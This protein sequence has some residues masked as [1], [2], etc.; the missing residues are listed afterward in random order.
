MAEQWRCAGELAQLSEDNP[1]EYKLDGVEVGIFKVGG[2]I[3]ALENV[4]PHAYAL[5]TQGFI[6]GETVECP[7]HEAVFHIPSGKCLK[8]PGGRDLKTYAVRLAGE[9]IQIKVE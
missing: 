6:D 8:E 1:I 9:E 4:C 3:Y 5:L 2:Q 7:L